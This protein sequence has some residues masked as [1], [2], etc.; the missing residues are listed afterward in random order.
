MQI[1]NGTV[2]SK[3]KHVAALST[4]GICQA[5]PVAPFFVTYD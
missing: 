3:R 2:A 1:V 4:E 5:A